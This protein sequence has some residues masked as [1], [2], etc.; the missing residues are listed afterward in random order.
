MRSS[1]DSGFDGLPSGRQP[2]VPLSSN[3]PVLLAAN[4]RAPALLHVL[5]RPT[6]RL[7]CTSDHH[8]S[9]NLLGARGLKLN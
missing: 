3:E 1:A 6:V 9:L 7:R 5:Y 2:A 4:S 8:W